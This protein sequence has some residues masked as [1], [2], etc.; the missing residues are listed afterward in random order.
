MDGRRHGLSDPALSG[1]GLDRRKP[2]KPLDVGNGI[3]SGS[4]T[5]NGRWLSLGLA[6]PIHGRIELTT[7]PPFT[8]ELFVQA[9]V[10]AYRASLAESV[11]LSFGF[12]LLD[13]EPSRV[14]LVA[15]SFP[16][17]FVERSQGRFEVTTVAPR[18]RQGA[19][20][21]LRIQA[22]AAIV[23]PSWGGAMRLARAEFTQLTPRAPLPPAPERNRS[24]L[25]DDVFWIE[26]SGLG[27]AAA[28][29]QTPALKVDEGDTGTAVLAIALAEDRPTAVKEARELCAQGE[30]LAARELA[31]RRTFWTG[32][33]LT[34]DEHA[35]I[36]RGVAYAL[37]EAASRSG[38]AVA[39][40]ADHVIL[41]LVW[42]RDAYFV[43]RA[44]L[45]AGP[46]E[47]SV[48]AVIE[49]FLRF[50]FERAERVGGSWPRASLPSGQA[51]D[52][53][54]QLDQQLWPLLLLADYARLTG[55]LD[56]HV[57]FGAAVGA[58]IETLLR[59]RQPFGLIATDETPADD[60]LTQ[61]YHFS[62]HVLLWHV[63]DV[64]RD[65]AASD[66]RAATLRH[67][68]SEGRFAYAIAGPHAEGARQYHD[69]NDF[70]TVFAP[71][72]GFCDRGDPRWQATI[73]FAWSTANEAYLP[74]PL[75][76]LGS[77]HTLHP[78]PLG[79]LQEI[80]V[81]RVMK[82]RARE[83]RAKE[84]LARVETWDGMLPEA[85]DETSGVVASRHWFAWPA[86]LRALLE[87]EP[88]LTAP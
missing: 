29:A 53:V 34:R 52:P 75:G 46:H 28:I 33:G 66:V 77:V 15:D 14:E 61:P 67:F 23:G 36:R 26:D 71:G 24:K 10:R 42:T 27:A 41:P 19:V 70:P 55:D 31:D 22:R 48:A 8:G 62:S 72:W 60:P 18:G 7:A 39:V 16:Y 81:A 76:G 37:D 2:Y 54:F 50:A 4:L 51:M 84:R 45:A 85:Y 20:Q 88:M 35:P 40:L 1:E 3:V 30:A 56:V 6:H 65:A 11:R 47:P 25:E 57:R 86:A 80:V 87:R 13:D 32:L 78:W 9:A 73:A 44:L 79:D 49:G 68:E 74:G 58:V 63:L 5:A 17:A 38:D 83:V 82:D 21:I 64:F 59:R 43:C 69:A 12:D